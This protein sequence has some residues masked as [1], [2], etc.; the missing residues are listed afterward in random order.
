MSSGHGPRTSTLQS[1][2]SIPSLSDAKAHLLTYLPPYTVNKF[3]HPWEPQLPRLSSGE[4][5][6][7]LDRAWHDLCLLP[8][9]S[10]RR[11]PGSQMPKFTPS[12]GGDVYSAMSN[13]L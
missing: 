2:D 5:Y 7:W 11:L 1:Q 10:S 6:Q 9:R 8:G 4:R 13:C 12:G 3:L